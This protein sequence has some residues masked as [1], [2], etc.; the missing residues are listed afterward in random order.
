MQFYEFGEQ[1]K[2]VIVLVHGELMSW[3]MLMPVIDRL[4]QDIRVIAVAL[5]GHDPMTGDVFISIE[6]VAKRIEDYLLEKGLREIDGIY[7]LLIGGSIAMRMYYDNRVYIHNYAIASGYMPQDKNGLLKKHK[8]SKTGAKVSVKMLSNKKL[9]KL[10]MD[11]DERLADMLVWAAGKVS[12]KSVDN[13]VN[14][15]NTL[16]LPDIAPQV[17]STFCY[18]ASTLPGDENWIDSSDYFENYIP[19]SRTMMVPGKQDNIKY[20]LTCVDDFC[21]NLKS[22]LL[23]KKYIQNIS[24]DEVLA[25][26][27]TMTEQLG[28]DSP[29]M[30]QMMQYLGINI[31]IPKDN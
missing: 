20:V 23:H 31:N 13:I 7:G 17:D 4:K 19:N 26:W 1:K 9:A 27:K 18:W 14:S 10:A 8:F 15:I 21:A 29:T 3:D 30:E 22:Q 5:P 6:D 2:E 25:G 12:S 24:T 16:S 28:T 11:G